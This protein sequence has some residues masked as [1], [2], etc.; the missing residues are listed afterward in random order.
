MRSRASRLPVHV[1]VHIVLTGS[2]RVVLGRPAVD[3]DLPGQH[4]TLEEVLVALATAEP[5]IARYLRGGAGLL[6]SFLRP[7]LDDRPLEL[8]SPIPDGATVTLLHAVAGG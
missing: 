6:P 8:Q 4:C 3:L 5:S 7:L 1:R 2:P